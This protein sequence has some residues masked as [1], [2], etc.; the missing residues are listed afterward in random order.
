MAT[1]ETG[2][3]TTS[4]LV[5]RKRMNPHQF[6]ASL[7]E[8]KFDNAFNPYTS[9]CDVHDVDD[10]PQRRRTML[11]AVLTVAVTQDVDSIWIG[12]DLGYRGGRRTGLALTDD[13]HT[14]EYAAR[15]G[16]HFPRPTRGAILTERTAAVIW[17]VLS[18]IN[19]PIFLWNVF[20][21]HPHEPGK[22][23]S[24]RAH[25]HRERRI[26]EELLSQLV[27]LLGPHRLVAIG[28]AAASA[29]YR[30]GGERRVDHVR[31]PSYGGQGQF[32]TQMC[33]IYGLEFRPPVQP[34]RSLFSSGFEC[35]DAA[36]RAVAVNS[37]TSYG[38]GASHGFP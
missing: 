38:A 5:H 15:W 21:L 31:H 9:R 20:P 27:E 36:Q 25:N 7:S 10:A 28:N 18:R 19:A 4:L 26:G 11:L 13:A 1:E 2:Q 24:N 30:I 17:R 8:L 3:L 34:S 14:Q 32:V 23:F 29:V 35:S 6:V 37:H 16:V 33:E 12:R 22:P